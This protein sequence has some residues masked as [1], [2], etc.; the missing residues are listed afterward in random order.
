[1]VKAQSLIGTKMIMTKLAIYK[2]I[3][4][5]FLIDFERGQEV[6]IPEELR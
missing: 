1:M 2:V 6:L 4:M 3:K 5:I